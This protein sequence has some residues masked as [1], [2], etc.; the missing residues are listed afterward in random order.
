MKGR[1]RSK[2]EIWH[3]LESEMGRGFSDD[4]RSSVEETTPFTATVAGALGAYA[5]LLEYVRNLLAD[6]SSGRVRRERLSKNSRAEGYEKRRLRL[7]SQFLIKRA[8]PPPKI[9]DPSG[10]ADP[11]GVR[12]LRSEVNKEKLVTEEQAERLL[13]SPAARFLPINWF[14]RH[15][16][17][18]FAHQSRIK[19]YEPRSFRK[20]DF[21]CIE[22]KLHLEIS[23]GSRKLQE[24]M[25]PVWGT[26]QGAKSEELPTMTLP[27]ENGRTG[28][29]ALFRQSVLAKLRD[30]S[31]AVAEA[32]RWDVCDAARFVLCGAAP[33]E[34]GIRY[35][36][37]P[38]WGPTIARG[39]F[40]AEEVIVLRVDSWLSPSTVAAAYGEIQRL[41]LG[42]RSR[43]H[44]ASLELMELAVALMEP[45]GFLPDDERLREE[46]NRKFPR[47]AYLDAWRFRSR[48]SEA[49]SNILTPG[50]VQHFRRAKAL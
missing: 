2:T 40:P 10:M 16:V 1:T 42:G 17:P 50:K 48:Y 36:V 33:K 49:F 25:A 29:V 21:F 22:R 19:S 20:G 5:G 39:S 6:P 31:I 24:K 9:L 37:Q 47:R 12:R 14:R 43:A 38:E 23:W 8:T 32:C 18:L 27:L 46:W 45:G 28:E 44:D 7:R 26:M 30:V 11:H 41:V 13:S 34:R 15:R 3:L 35:E 4:F